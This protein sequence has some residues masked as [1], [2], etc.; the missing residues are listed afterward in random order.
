MW[1]GT[2]KSFVFR[3]RDKT[4]GQK[5]VE[6]MDPEGVKGFSHGW[7]DGRRSAAIAEPVEWGCSIRLLPRQ[8]QRNGKQGV[9]R[10]R[11]RV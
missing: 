5:S 6:H 8:G 1:A 11:V 4:G 9:S 10:R 2:R 3:V 7:S